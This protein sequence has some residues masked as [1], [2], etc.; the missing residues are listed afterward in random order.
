LHKDGSGSS[1]LR[2]LYED[3]DRHG[4]VRLYYR[5]NGKKIRLKSVIGTQAF[6]DE[7]AAVA[8]TL[9]THVPPKT[10]VPG[11]LRWLV[12]Q[13]YSSFEF[14]ALSTRTQ[15]VRRRELTEICETKGKSGVEYGD[16]SYAKM[17]ARHVRNLR[18]EKADRPEAANQRIKVLRQ[19]FQWAIEN[20]YAKY[21]PARDVATLDADTDGFHTWTT[22]EVRKYWDRH[23]I[24]TKARLAIDLL[25]FTGVRRSDVVRLG[26]PMESGNG[27]ALRWTEVKGRKRKI[28]NRE[29]PILPQLRASIDA[30]DTGKDTYL[31][32]AFGKP[33]TSNGF[34]NWIKKRTTEAGLMGCTAHGVRKAGAT[35]AADNGATEYELMAIFG[36][37][38]AKEA[39]RYTRHANRKRLAAG[40]LRLVAPTEPAQKV[41]ATD[42]PLAD[43]NDPPAKKRR[44]P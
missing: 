6:L 18:S 27:D 5:R 37:E 10:V 11:S 38:S 28:K 21:N 8:E 4:N 12:D 9:K 17:E 16:R 7:Y 43:A 35:I 15:Y 30:T 32:T 25:L 26:P 3:V 23:P 40:A 14:Q 41:N 39:A 19:L 33:F 1:R 29:L 36:W 20:K 2:Y 13:Y 22:E 34:G 42:P 31:V 24:G 44:Q